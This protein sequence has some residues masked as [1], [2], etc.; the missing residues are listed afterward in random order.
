MRRTMK[1]AISAILCA[2]MVMSMTGCGSKSADVPATDTTASTDGTEAAET[3]DAA[4][5]DKVTL[6]VWHQWSNDTNEL[7]AIYEKAVEDYMAENPNVVINS[8]TLDTEAYKTKISAEFAGDASGIDVFYYW[9]AGMARK[10]VN[11][12]KLLPLDDYLTD[13][14]KGRILEG[15]TSAFTYDGK[16]YSVPS[17]SWYMTL[18][19]NQDLFDKAGAKIPTTYD[20]LL[21]ACKKLST[22][23]GV[24][25]MA[26]GAKDGWNAAFIYQALALREM[27][28]ADVNKMLAGETEFGGDGYK[29]A[30]DKVA[31][32]Y[33]AGAFGKNPLESGNDDANSAFISG[34]AAMRLMGSWFANQVYTDDTATIDPSKVV[35][36]KIP[37]ITGK[38]NESDYC[39]GFVE[40]FWVNK[41]TKYP[42]EAAKF[43]IYINEKMGVAAYETGSGFSGWTTE[44]D[45]SNLNPLFIQIKDL[46]GEGKEGVLAWDTSLDSEP[47]T[48]HNEQAQTL[49]APNADT[50]SFMEEHEAAINQ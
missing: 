8:E 50:E 16:L 41:N 40:S 28:A 32:L 12:D 13:D 33:N 5:G 20:E 4:G 37:M 36:C 19:C 39:G 49:F 44:A 10:L 25:P 42:E 7:K 43:A 47:A 31:E 1:K 27:G 48:I 38:G 17:F 6:N 24:T 11:A 46:L 30:A 2:A 29:A 35:A 34:T 22:L 23:D 9:G 26:A 21:D 15:S 14:V 3:A 18:F 45:E